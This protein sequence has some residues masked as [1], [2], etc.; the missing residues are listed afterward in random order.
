MT[1]PDLGCSAW[2][3]T[4]IVAEGVAGGGVI[5]DQWVDGNGERNY[6][7]V[8]AWR[9]KVNYLTLVESDIAHVEPLNT[10]HLRKLGTFL[11][12]RA[13]Y[14]KTDRHLEAQLII[15]RLLVEHDQVGRRLHRVAK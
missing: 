4:H 15:S 13:Y 8:S 12:D 9:T 14:E 6:A 3:K 1:A 10:A 5:I 2:S 11:R 7:T